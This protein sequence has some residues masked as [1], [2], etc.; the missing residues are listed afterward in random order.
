[1]KNNRSTSKGKKTAKLVLNILFYTIAVI[2]MI[3]AIM[4]LIGKFTGRTVPI[5]GYSAYVV[6]SPSMATTTTKYEEFLK[7]DKRLDVGDLIITKKIK[8]EDELQL[9]TI[10]TFNTLDNKTIVHRI[11]NLNP[12]PDGKTMYTTRGDANLQADG[13]FSSDEFTG[14][15]VSNL[16][17]FGRVIN[18]LGSV[19][20]LSC[21][22]AIGFIYFMVMFILHQMEEKE[23]KPK[24]PDDLPEGEEE[25]A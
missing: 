20:G 13:A 18:F 11:V 4:G 9:H 14:I 23:Q 24:E 7:D 6:V 2:I 19:Y 12:G 8:S 3:L 5:F 25:N 21:L 15:V 1:M 10:V 16:G 22:G 17:Q